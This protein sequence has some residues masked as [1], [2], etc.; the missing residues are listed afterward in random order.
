MVINLAHTAVPNHHD[1][2]DYAVRIRK[3]MPS[4]RAKLAGWMGFMA[5]ES[6]T[7]LSATPAAES[8]HQAIA[9]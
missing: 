7:I 4:S 6:Q 1:A 3:W 2:H 8:S 5:F 9:Q